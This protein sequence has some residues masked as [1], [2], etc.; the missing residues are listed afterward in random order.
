MLHV[1]A[2]TPRLTARVRELNSSENLSFR[3]SPSAHLIFKR[4]SRRSRQSYS[5]S[6]QKNK[7]F[8]DPTLWVALDN[9]GW[10][11]FMVFIVCT[12]TAEAAPPSAVFGRWAPRTMEMKRV[13]VRRTWPSVEGGHW[14]R[15]L[16]ILS[17]DPWCS[18]SKNAKGG[19]A[20]VIML[21]ARI[22]AG[23]APPHR[24]IIW[25]L[26]RV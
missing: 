20:S 14:M 21:P 18:P 13:G 15:R 12:I 1:T 22:K 25:P 3:F 2:S 9:G 17:R 4:L 7:S 11:T 26:T 16:H 19:A 23:P 5:G 24:N 8:S 6:R 10:P